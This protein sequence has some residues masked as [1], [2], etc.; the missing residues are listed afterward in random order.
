M[1][2]L[3]PADFPV[4]FQSDRSAKG[5]VVALI[6]R[7][8][9]PPDWHGTAWPAIDENVLSTECSWLSYLCQRLADISVRWITAV[10]FSDE[11]SLFPTAL[12]RNARGDRDAM[13]TSSQMLH[14]LSRQCIEDIVAQAVPSHANW[15]WL[16]EGI[17]GHDDIVGHC[18][19]LHALECLEMHVHQC[20]LSGISGCLSST[21]QWIID[22]RQ[23][24]FTKPA[25]ETDVNVSNT[26]QIASSDVLRCSIEQRSRSCE[27][28]R[29][30]PIRH[31]CLGVG[32]CLERGQICKKCN[33]RILTI[34]KVCLLHSIVEV[35]R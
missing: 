22:K 24:T 34:N 3:N 27:E 20:V 19:Q 33:H 13:V 35:G 10:Q 5:M 25:E 32:V 4:V 28:I 23:M 9:Y 17:K 29:V 31:Q 2:N 12:N 6:N 1:V 21:G 15:V 30:V 7:C 16:G 11:W 26:R 18:V 8:H 14:Y